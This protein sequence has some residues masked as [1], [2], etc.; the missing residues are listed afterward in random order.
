MNLPH[1][2]WD[3]HIP[4]LLYSMRNTVNQ[5]TKVTPSEVLFNQR[6]R[7]PTDEILEEDAF[8]YTDGKEELLDKHQC[9]IE[10][11]RKYVRAYQKEAPNIQL[12][13]I[14]SMVFIKN[15]EMSNAQRGIT[16]SLN[17]KWIGPYSVME[18]YPPS[19]YTCKSIDNPQDIRKVSHKDTQARPNIDPAKTT[20]R[21]DHPDNTLVPKGT[22]EEAERSQVTTND[23]YYFHNMLPDRTEQAV[24]ESHEIN[25]P[26][27]TPSREN[28]HVHAYTNPQQR[29]RNPKGRERKINPK[30]YGPS[31]E[32]NPW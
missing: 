29:R 8:N 18:A 32:S 10:N 9:A 20:L 17:P 14:G 6:L 25:N 2:K 4:Q 21:A 1:S 27:T 12:H 23:L 31:W 30:Y 16:S 13:P 24:K 26:K 11:Q 28:Y 3:Q 7:H 5:A 22:I 19:T 15:H